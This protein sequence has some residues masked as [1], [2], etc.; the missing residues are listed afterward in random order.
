M[1]R[2]L[3]RR[4]RPQ[5]V[6]MGSDATVR[7]SSVPHGRGV[8]LGCPCP[9]PL[10]PIH[11]LL[12]LPASA[13]PMPGPRMPVIMQSNSNLVWRLL[14]PSGPFVQGETRQ[15]AVSHSKKLST[16]SAQPPTCST[17]KRPC[18]SSRALGM[19]A[20]VL[21]RARAKTKPGNGSHQVMR[22]ANLHT[23]QRSN[24]QPRSIILAQLAARA[25]AANRARLARPLGPPSHPL[26]L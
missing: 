23:W 25:P 22:R 15:R 26:L 13:P 2:Q 11:M 16:C 3:Q 19:A 1:L 21:L 10:L 7:C 4:S 12:A 17:G 5:I 6:R 9:S 20:R 18:T 14:G 24:S 8:Q